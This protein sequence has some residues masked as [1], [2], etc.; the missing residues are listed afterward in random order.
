MYLWNFLISSNSYAPGNLL[1][2]H[3]PINYQHMMF[4]I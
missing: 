4:D 2:D 1:N 3:V